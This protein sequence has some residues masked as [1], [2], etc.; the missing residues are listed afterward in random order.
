[1]RLA[2]VVLSGTREIDTA[3]LARDAAE[4]LVKATATLKPGSVEVIGPAP[5]AV[6]RIKD[7]WRWHL[8]LRSW[9]PSLLTQVGRR[10]MTAFD[11]PSRAGL[12]VTFD[13][14]PVSLL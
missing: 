12:R 5:C 6:D 4:W 2:N 10:F 1:V 9:K 7:R 3:E 11:V 8:V 14:D 13:R